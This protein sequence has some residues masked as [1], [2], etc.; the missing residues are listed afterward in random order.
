MLLVVLQVIVTQLNLVND[1]SQGGV[2]YVVDEPQT[3]VGR[4]L[5][6][7]PQAAENRRLF[8]L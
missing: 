7:S 3:V 2:V 4:R 8:V 5:S 1:G 6:I